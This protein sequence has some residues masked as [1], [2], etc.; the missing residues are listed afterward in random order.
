[1][2][3]QDRRCLRLEPWVFRCTVSTISLRSTLLLQTALSLRADAVPPK[4]P[5]DA[6]FG[7]EA[8]V[9]HEEMRMHFR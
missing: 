7:P 1:V 8:E 4:R 2:Q 9:D 6:E 3:A 5:G